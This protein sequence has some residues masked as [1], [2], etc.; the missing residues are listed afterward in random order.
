MAAGHDQGQAARRDDAGPQLPGVTTIWQQPIRNRID[1]L[2]TGIPTQVGVKVFG[3]DLAV[4]EK[5][6]SEIAEVVR[7]VPGAADVYAEQILGTPY[8]EIRVDREA[9]ARYGVR[10]G[11]VARGDRDGD[12]RR[13]PD[14]DD[15]GAEPFRG[16]GPLRPRAARRHREARAHAGAAMGSA[17]MQSAGSCRRCRWPSWRTSTCAPARP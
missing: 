5:K 3:P 4:L 17:P 11:D 1:M 12:R 7:A 13:E 14:D 6:A 9:A 10:V 15:R 8:L 2:A 16:P